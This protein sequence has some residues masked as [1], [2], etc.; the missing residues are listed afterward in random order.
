[1]IAMKMPLAGE[2]RR[3]ARWPCASTALLASV[4]LATTFSTTAQAVPSYAR[5]TGSECAACHIGSFGPQL[6]P[7]G[8]RFK[9]GGYTDTDG[10]DGKVPISAMA[11]ANWTRSTKDLPE[12]PAHFSTNNNAAVQEV[13][14][15][16]AGRLTDHI[17][18]FIQGTYSGVDRKSFLDQVDIRY[19]STLNLGE[20]EGVV[21]ISLNNNPTLTDPFNTLAQWRFPYTA[22]DF[23]FGTGAA[24]LVENLGGSVVGI[25]A[26]TLW[27]KNF[28]AELGVY[29]ALSGNTVNKINTSQVATA[30][31]DPGKFSGVGTYWRLAYFKDMKRD[32]FN[33]GVFGFNAGVE[34]ANDPG[35]ADHYQDLGIDASYQFLGN[36]EHIFTVNASYVWE[37]QNLNYTYN[38]LGASQHSTD[39]LDTF[40]LATSY[41]YKQTWGATAGLFDTRGSSDNGLYGSVSYNNRP[42]TSGYILQADWTPWGKEGSWGAPWANVRLGLQYTGYTRFNGGSHYIDEVN[43]IDRK[44]TDNNTTMLF[45]WLAI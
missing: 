15:F 22:S 23:G 13:S 5:Q 19:A 36:R 17:G 31:I 21:G 2:W 40:R 6:T 35:S 1:M 8:I 27:D 39:T 14:L 16:L 12:A 28:Y 7:Y 38:A 42:D 29:R 3:W 45:L 26:Y 24:P 4:L 37:K 44:A 33:V 11:V 43:N 32:N 18:T 10:K 25:N 30:T 41:H 34:N 20:Q 9:V